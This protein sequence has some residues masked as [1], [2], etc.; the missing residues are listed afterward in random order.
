MRTFSI[1]KTTISKNWML[2]SAGIV[3][4]ISAVC[5]CV[6]PKWNLVSE[7]DLIKEGDG[8]FHTVKKGE[9]LY[10]ICKTYGVS[11][12]VVAEE[13]D[14][15]EPGSMR[16]GDRL[17]IPGSKKVLEVDPAKVPPPKHAVKQPEPKQP[18]PPSKTGQTPEKKPDKLIARVGDTDRDETRPEKYRGIFIWPVKGVVISRFGVRHGTKHMGVDISA[19]AGT[20]ITAAA[21]GEVIYSDNKLR[22]YGNL[23]L[24]RHDKGFISVY[25]HN[26]EN[27]V[28][29]GDRV[30]QGQK[31]ALLGSTGNAEAPHLHFEIREGSTARNPMFFLP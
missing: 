5:G 13:N 6:H 26:R 25:A 12:Q 28:K 11:L 9:T 4:G 7:E 1:K 30:V 27:L 21:G 16:I 15:D 20:P 24:I 2:F 23:V 14:I 10:S 8:V 31:I 22:G 3:F 19:P 18:P 29:E 17:F